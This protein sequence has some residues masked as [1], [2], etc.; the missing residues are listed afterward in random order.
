MRQAQIKSSLQT[1]RRGQSWPANATSL[2][3]LF[4]T[5]EPDFNGGPNCRMSEAARNDLILFE[6]GLKSLPATTAND[7]TRS[8]RRAL[9]A[10]TSASA[11][12]AS[13]ESLP[14]VRLIRSDDA[15]VYFRFE[16]GTVEILRVVPRDGHDP[17]APARSA[18]P[19]SSLAPQ[20]VN[21]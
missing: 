16:N 2:P 3:W 7:A 4:S 20:S 15:E 10:T 13:I 14:D 12:A 11:S 8:L 21:R 18:S 19:T 6:S 17:V 9:L 1:A 5:A